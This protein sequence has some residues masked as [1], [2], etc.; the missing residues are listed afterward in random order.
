MHTPTF[1]QLLRNPLHLLAFGLG[2]GLSPKAPGTVGTLL[3]V[4]LLPL[5]SQLPLLAYVAM[6]VLAAVAGVYFCGRTAKDLGVHDHPGIVWDEIAGF[7]LAMT[8]IPVTWLWV[9]AG[10]VL[11]R[12]FDVCKPWPISW[13]D[14]H[15]EGGVG[16]ML[17]DL[18]AGV[19]TW[20]I[21]F[22]VSYYF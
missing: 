17:D 14:R 18:L 7:W 15:V 12:I 22:S 1:L 20:V 3:A 11:F 5:L 21:L 4:A 2:S 19:F 16:I 6:V 10:F 13:C 8:A 9:L